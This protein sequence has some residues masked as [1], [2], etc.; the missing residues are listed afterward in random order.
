M[1]PSQL[2]LSLFSEMLPNELVS[3]WLGRFRERYTGI[4]H[5]ALGEILGELPSYRKGFP[6][7]LA[8]IAVAAALSEDELLRD[9]TFLPFASIELSKAEREALVV[10]LLTSNAPVNVP[11]RFTPRAGATLRVCHACIEADLRHDQRAPYYR[12]IHQLHDLQLCPEHHTCL[13]VT[14]V[15]IGAREFI[16]PE[17]ALENGKQLSYNGCAAPVIAA[18]YVYALKHPYCTREQVLPILE[19]LLAVRGFIRCGVVDYKLY[20]LIERVHGASGLWGLDFNDHTAVSNWVTIPHLA[21]ACSALK[22]DFAEFM[23]QAQ[24]NRPDPVQ[25]LALTDHQREL[26]ARVQVDAP[27][28]ARNLRHAGKK[29]TVWALA[30]ALDARYQ[31]S[32]ASNYSWRPEFRAMLLAHTRIS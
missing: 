4:S 31:M 7:R 12:C 28:I 3:S 9:H 29:V 15:P 10:S 14:K 16:P 23:H 1:N 22:I 26:L 32:F 30:T 18:G 2:P 25:P 21:L 20:R 17:E 8:P 13:T 24:E 19:R 5:D 11:R 27:K 6:T